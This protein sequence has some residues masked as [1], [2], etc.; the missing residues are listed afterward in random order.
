MNCNLNQTQLRPKTN[1]LK[2]YEHFTSN[3]FLDISDIACVK[4][5]TVDGEDVVEGAEKID[6][7]N[8]KSKNDQDVIIQANIGNRNEET[9]EDFKT[10]VDNLKKAIE[11]DEDIKASIAKHF[12]QFNSKTV[13]E[14]YLD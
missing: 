10:N 14:D 4:V 3:I 6:G 1:F 2:L 7:S 12:S 9:D 11:N 8:V 13:N 5:D